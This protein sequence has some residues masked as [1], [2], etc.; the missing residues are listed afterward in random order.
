MVHLSNRK[1]GKSGVSRQEVPPLIAYIYLTRKSILVFPQY[2]RA[3][4]IAI[5]G[6]SHDEQQIG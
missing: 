1:K 4:C 2:V 6:A 5:D 3:I